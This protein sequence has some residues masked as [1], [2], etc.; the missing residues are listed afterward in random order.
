MAQTS[1]LGP[2]KTTNAWRRAMVYT[3]PGNDNNSSAR[4]PVLY[5]QHGGG[6]DERG[7]VAQGH[8]NFILDNL[9][10]DGKAK[11]MLIVMETGTPSKPG[12][13]SQALPFR[14]ST[15]NSR[16]KTPATKPAGQVPVKFSQDFESLMIQDLI[17]MIDAN[18]RTIA[19]RDRWAMAGL[20]MAGMQTFQ[21]GLN[22]LDTFSYLGGFSGAGGGFGPPGAVPLDARTAY[23]GVL[24]DGGELNKKVHLVWVSVGTLEGKM[25]TGIKAFHEALGQAGVRHVYYQSP[26]TADEWQTWRRSLHGFAPLL[27]QTDK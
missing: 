19:D 27:F 22:H 11:P 14:G 15:P 5:L 21:I 20:S 17:P 9:I 16:A 1:I 24:A 7:W 8:V 13:P 2:A 12:A 26:G 4:Y 25:Y 23:H 3:P 6:E 18:F 10:A